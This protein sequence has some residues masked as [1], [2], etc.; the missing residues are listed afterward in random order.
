MPRLVALVCLALL[1]VTHAHAAARG[2]EHWQIDSSRCEEF[3]STY[4]A[5]VAEKYMGKLSFK[6][7]GFINAFKAS[8]C[9]RQVVPEFDPSKLDRQAYEDVLA[10]LKI[11]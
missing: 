9:T 10:R 1:S 2:N 3:F 5:M 8:N 6:F 7:V 4:R 11:V